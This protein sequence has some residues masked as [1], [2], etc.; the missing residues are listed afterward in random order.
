MPDHVV[1][2]SSLTGIESPIVVV[3]GDRFPMITAHKVLAAYACLAPRVV[4]GQF[5]PTRHRA[6]WPSTGNY[7]RGGIAI[8]RLMASRGVAILP[9]GMSQERFDWLDRWCDEPGRGRHPHRRH[10][11]QRQG[12]LRRVQRARRRTRRTSCSTSSASSATTS[13]TTRSPVGRSTMRSRRRAPRAGRSGASP[14]SSAPPAR[15]ARSPPATASRSVHGSITVAVEAL[16]CPTMLDNGFGEHNIQG[17]GDKHIPLIHN[18][19][20]TDVVVGDQRPGH[21]RARRAVQHA[22]RPGVPRRPQGRAA[23]GGG[24][25]GA[26]RAVVDLQRAGGDQDRQAAR[27]RARRRDR[28]RGH[29]RRGDVPERAGQDARASASPA[30][31]TPSPRPR[32]SASTWPMSTS[33][34]T[35][36]L[37]ERDRNRI[38]NLGYYTWVEQQ[39]TPFELFEARRSQ[40]FWRD[41]RRFLPRVGRDDPRVQRARRRRV[42][43]P[44][45][46]TVGLRCSVCG[47]HVDIATPF[48]WRCP[49]ATALDRRHALAF[50]E[51]DGVAGGP[52][53]ELDALG[54][55][56]FGRF[57]PWLA[58]DAF[59]AANGMSDAMR[60]RARW[61]ALDQPLEFAVTPFGRDAGLSAALGFS[62]GGGVWIKDET[63]QV[64]GSHKARH[65]FT[66]LLHLRTAEILGLA[67]WRAAGERPPLAIASCGNA[68][69][70][71]ATL[72]SSADW[73]LVGVRPADRRSGGARPARRA[74][75]DD[76]AVSAPGRRSARRSVRAPL[77]R[78][79]RRRCGAVQRAGHGER[80]VPRRWSHDRLGDGRPRASTLDRLFV[81]VGGGALAACAGAGSRRASA[82][83]PVARG[84]DRRRARR[85][86]GPGT[87]RRR[88]I[89]ARRRRSGRR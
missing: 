15:P 10:G 68:A 65:L 59:A 2:P 18:V 5:D 1:L 56:T 29:R 52:L 71:A 85:W 86:Y 47:A 43:S 9:E 13:A 46:A 81:Q 45:P 67:P 14:R 11:E 3:L 48:S 44:G 57:R 19:T 21:R 79:R 76:R 88:R 75:G 72:A 69:I 16:E 80:V 32:C 12:D 83:G 51:G 66:I 28:H 89:G 40:R 37:T 17:I 31:S 63:G 4:T 61:P 87:A 78:G 25:A 42:V 54:S 26:L 27:L 84:A 7:A 36:Q 35:Q 82:R 23:G 24:R 34:A 53:P 22:G 38:F 8:S 20:N 62:A 60:G 70:A 77:P 50:V 41:L 58:W 64:G 30:R 33:S 6:I 73:P 55:G 39:G 49:N 74:P